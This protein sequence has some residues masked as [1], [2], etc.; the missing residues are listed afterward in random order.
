ML[1]VGNDF[2]YYN[3]RLKDFELSELIYK[4]FKKFGQSNLGVKFN[5]KYSTPSEYFQQMENEHD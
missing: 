2:S 4:I 1:L 5:V 3:D